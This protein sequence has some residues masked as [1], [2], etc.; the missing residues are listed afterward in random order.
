M[1]LAIGV[2]TALL[3]TG[4]AGWVEK[5]ASTQCVKAGYAA[6]TAENADCARQK[7]AGWEAQDRQSTQDIVGVAAVA[8]GAYAVAQ[9][10]PTYAVPGAREAPLVGQSYAN[11]QRT[12]TYHTPSG[13]VNLV[14]AGGQTCPASYSY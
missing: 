9:A 3:L 5:A 2:G 7:M 11:Y 14:T 6:G 12:C 13:N 10:A 4:C 1:K 8:A